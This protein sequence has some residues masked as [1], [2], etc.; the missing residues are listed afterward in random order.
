MPNLDLKK[1]AVPPSSPKH[2]RHGRYLDFQKA[3]ATRRFWWRMSWSAVFLIAASLFT[4]QSMLASDQQALT[5]NYES[6]SV[7]QGIRLNNLARYNALPVEQPNEKVQILAEYLKEKNSPLAA[8]AGE[9]ARLP[10]WK[11][12]VGIANAESNL[13]KKT[14]RN[15]CWG[16]GPGGPWTFGEITESLYYANYLLSKFGKLG[17]DKPESLVRTYVGWHN[18]NWVNAIRDVFYELQERGLQ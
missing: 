11:L 2:S 4:T 15:N 12:L 1:V 7:V 13:C 5:Q 17:M 9:L 6:T 10:N 14:D 3:K 16:I 18:P 8:Y